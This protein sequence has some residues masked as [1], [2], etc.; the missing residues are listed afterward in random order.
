VR[1]DFNQTSTPSRRCR[2]RRPRGDLNATQAAIRA[3][4]SPRTAAQIGY[5][6]LRKAEI[7]AA[8]ADACRKLSERT[9]ATADRVITELAKIAFANMADYLKP[10]PAGGVYFDF[11]GF[12]G[13]RSS[14]RK[15]A[16][17]N[18]SL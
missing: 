18:V 2:T 15:R 1:A 10:A 4:Y 6:N 12:N 5:A 8:I 14:W 17:G 3:G 11:A 7:S 9:Q 16:A 13:T